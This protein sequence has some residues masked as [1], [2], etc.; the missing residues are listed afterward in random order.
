MTDTLDETGERHDELGGVVITEEQR[1][2]FLEL[3]AAN[4]SAPHVRTLRELGVEGSRGQIHDAIDR[5]LRADIER[6]RNTVIRREIMRRALE[7][8][9][10][11]VWHNGEVVGSKRVFSDRLLEFAGRTYLPEARNQLE[12]TGADGGP[13]RVEVEG[14]RVTSISDVIELA[15]QF[16]VAGA[17]GGLGAAAAR[18][19]LPPAPP[20]L[21]DPPD[22]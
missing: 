5:Q 1:D 12:V 14:G 18:R 22:G 19:A 8:V 2:A 3:V 6:V 15:S 11:D 4:P 16:G 13:L 17:R 21:P 9:E 7:G 20:V 10:E